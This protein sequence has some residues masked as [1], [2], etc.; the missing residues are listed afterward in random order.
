MVTTQEIRA[1][2]SAAIT[3]LFLFLQSGQF[4]TDQTYVIFGQNKANIK[5]HSTAIYFSKLP[6]KVT[7]IEKEKEIA[8][9]L[10]KL[11]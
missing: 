9:I 1:P 6:S 7:F 5:Q 8:L 3:F 2:V 11:H 4:V 10:F